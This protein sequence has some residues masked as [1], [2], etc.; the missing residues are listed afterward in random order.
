MRHR[1]KLLCLI[2][3][4]KSGLCS[5][6]LNLN[7]NTSNKTNKQRNITV[8]PEIWTASFLIAIVFPDNDMFNS[9]SFG[10]V[11]GKHYANSSTMGWSEMIA[12]VGKS[13]KRKAGAGGRRTCSQWFPG[14]GQQTVCHFRLTTVT[15]VFAGGHIYIYIYG[16]TCVRQSNVK[17]SVQ[18]FNQDLVNC[19]SQEVQSVEIA[20]DCHFHSSGG[21]TLGGSEWAMFPFFSGGYEHLSQHLYPPVSFCLV[22]GLDSATFQWLLRVGRKTSST[23]STT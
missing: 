13:N 4:N 3:G 21:S 1:Q 6:Y 10:H 5:C 20:T 11:F 8:P 18:I 9:C 23:K 2:F 12:L 17:E 19:G 7:Q 22:H 15:P 14:L 16:T